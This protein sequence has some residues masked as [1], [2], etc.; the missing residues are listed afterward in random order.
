[1][2]K[3]IK[4]LLATFLSIVLMVS[5]MTL[6]ANAATYS[7]SW[8]LQRTQSGTGYLVYSSDTVSLKTLETKY[9]TRVNCPDFRSTETA[10]GT[11]AYVSYYGFAADDYVGSDYLHSLFSTNYFYQARTDMKTIQFSSTVDYGEY[12]I[13]KFSLHRYVNVTCYFAGRVEM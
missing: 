5:V 6:N 10:D 2:T 13:A 3:G 1:M 11:I 7:D 12:Y 4:T 8:R 9:S